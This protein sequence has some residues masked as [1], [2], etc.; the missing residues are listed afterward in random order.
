[1][2]GISPEPLISGN[3]FEV[4]FGGTVS[5]TGAGVI[6]KNAC[7]GISA[8]LYARDVPGTANNRTV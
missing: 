8:F 2:Y 5:N 1:M 4:E 6:S 3:D 7:N